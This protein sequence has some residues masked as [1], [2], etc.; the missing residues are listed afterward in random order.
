MD[1]SQDVSSDDVYNRRYTRS[2]SYIMANLVSVIIYLA[3]L[4]VSGLFFGVFVFVY[5]KTDA[6]RIDHGK[7]FLFS[8]ISESTSLCFSS[9]AILGFLWILNVVLIV[10]GVVSIVGGRR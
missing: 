1:I 8:N 6:F 4:V 3:N 2:F 10:L 9:I 7:C 5:T